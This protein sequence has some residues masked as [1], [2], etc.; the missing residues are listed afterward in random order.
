MFASTATKLIRQNLAEQALLA[1]CILICFAAASTHAGLCYASASPLYS[2]PSDNAGAAGANPTAGII[3]G[4]DGNFYGTTALGGINDTGTIFE[5]TPS[6]T[7]TSLHN[8][9]DDSSF[10]NSDGAD[11]KGLLV[12]ASDGNFYGTTA[13]G[14]TYDDG[15]VFRI[16][17]TGVF[18]AIYSFDAVTGANP[19]AGLIQGSDGNFYGTTLLGGS[20]NSGSVFCITPLGSL[21]LLHSFSRNHNSGTAGNVD[22]AEPYAPLTLAANGHLYGTT[23]FGG[24]Y[25]SGTIF[26]MTLDG[27]FSVL[28][29]FEDAVDESD[30]V[31]TGGA[32]PISA[33]VQNS[34]GTIFGATYGGG[35]SGDGTLFSLAGDGGFTSVHSF[36]S[37]IDG[38]GPQ[39]SSIQSTDG[40]IIGTTSYGGLND[41]GTVFSLSPNGSISTLSAFGGDTDVDADGAG[42]L[43][44]LALGADGCIYGTSNQGGAQDTGSV[45][46]IAVADAGLTAQGFAQSEATRFDFNKD[47]NPD[48][49]WYNTVSGAMSIWDM[50]DTTALVYGSQLTQVSPA[51]G[52]LPVAAPD[53][54]DDGYPDLIWWNKLTG[55]LS[56][57]TMSNT[58]ILNFGPDFAELTP[59]SWKPVAAADVTGTTWELIFQNTDSGA[60]ST[61]QMDGTSVVS[62][63]GTLA[64]LG[65]GS[66]WQIVGAPDLNNDGNSDLLFWNS[67]T[68]EV[69][70]WFCRLSSNQVLSYNS[71][72]AQVPDTSWHLVGSEDT[73][74]DGHPDLLWWNVNTGEY[75][76][77]LL[78]GTT[79]TQYGGDALRVQDTNWQPT[80]IR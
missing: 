74:D 20:C 22:G 9:S 69:A 5:V 63:G 14:G 37:Q 49:I 76:R 80:A 67:S 6:G 53:I 19:Q 66:P 55:E 43:E 62:Y 24:A 4:S 30:Y 71:D 17:A 39:L 34:A 15:T 75:S 7:V 77:W 31:N 47:G 16:S 52:W 54:N 35:D 73:N 57:W 40:S 59:T 65:A 48:L 70:S 78:N 50:S 56:A 29:S 25:N 21:T 13:Y 1:A 18:A 33:L 44:G 32:N 60:I 10:F 42:P 68:G 61:W 41:E 79:V 3:R 8:F 11:P 45:F 51:S 36:N 64:S 26:E 46:K 72:F 2:F 27:Q 23:A 38:S 28:H 12:L 58:S